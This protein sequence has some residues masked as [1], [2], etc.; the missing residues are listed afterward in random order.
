V[1]PNI[2]IIFDNSGSMLANNADGSALCNGNGQ[3]SRIFRLKQALRETLAEIGTD[4][5]N[6]GLA[7]FPERTTPAMD[8][9]CPS[10]HYTNADGV[11]GALSGC[12]T[13]VANELAD[14]SW[15]APDVAPQVVVV[16]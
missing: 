14:G 10:G 8:R 7:R 11:A 2:L 16:R 9:G 15:F 3:N 1:R 5:A 4:E 12:R 6:F 13:S